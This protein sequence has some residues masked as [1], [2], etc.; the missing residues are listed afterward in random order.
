[1]KALK[2]TCLFTAALNLMVVIYYCAQRTPNKQLLLMATNSLVV[3]LLLISIVTGFCF[4]SQEKSRAF[5]PALVCFIGLL[6]SFFIGA[7]LGNA[8]KDWRFQ[9][10]LPRYNAVVGLIEKGDLK[11]TSENLFIKLPNEYADLA[12]AVVAKTN[13]NKMTIEFMTESGFPV[14]HS[15][16]LFISNGDIETDVNA[17]QH[18]PYHSR[19]NM[20]WFQISD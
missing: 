1:M 16:Y 18:W 14:K 17:L 4:C 19:I 13:N 6:A 3:I 2:F 7:C 5:V 8:I 15:G 12:W 9:K 11:P 20:N 10:D